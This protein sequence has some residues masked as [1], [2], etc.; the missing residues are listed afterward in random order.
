MVA[1]APEPPN[2][3]DRINFRV[4]ASCTF[5]GFLCHESIKQNRRVSLNSIGYITT[6]H[7]KR[8]TLIAKV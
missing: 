3:A 7:A 2:G 6:L 5:L 4:S 1:Q 8:A